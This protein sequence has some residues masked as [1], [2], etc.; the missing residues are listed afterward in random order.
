MATDRSTVERILSEASAAVEAAKLP[1]NLR[2]IAFEKAIDLLSG[3]A[4]VAETAGDS[5][6]DSGTGTPEVDTSS[7]ESFVRSQPNVLDRPAEA[8]KAIAAWWFS[9][10]GSAPITRTS[11]ETLAENIG[12]TIPDR[13]DAT[14]RQMKHDGRDVFR[15]AGRGTFVPTRPHGEL[16][17]Q[18]QYEV[19]KGRKQ[20]PGTADDS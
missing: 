13:P 15:S 9:Q 16:Y 12:V 17:F 8:V 4:K 19:S 1:Q 14:L 7:A 2:P 20:A 6:E 10:Y 3:G 11:V 18:T 5:D